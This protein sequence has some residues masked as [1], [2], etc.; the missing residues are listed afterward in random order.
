MSL[1]FCLDD[2]APLVSYSRFDE[3]AETLRLNTGYDTKPNNEMQQIAP[4]LE[5]RVQ[6]EGKG[7]LTFRND[8]FAGTRGENVAWRRLAFA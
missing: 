2:G 6:L 3:D 7:K 5:V 4:G 8:Q 1:N